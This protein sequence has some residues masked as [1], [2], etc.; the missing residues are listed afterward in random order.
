MG[1]NGGLITGR[2]VGGR[3]AYNQK[4][5]HSSESVLRVLEC[6]HLLACFHLQTTNVDMFNA[7]TAK[8]EFD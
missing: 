6:F 8:G 5:M 7:F 4:I 2:E 3:K 1:L